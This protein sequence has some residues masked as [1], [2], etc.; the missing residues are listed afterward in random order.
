M[1]EDEVAGRR[2]PLDGREFEHASGLGDG[3]GAW[4]AAAPGV[5]GTERQHSGSRSRGGA[6]L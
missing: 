5:G 6:L 1:T 4:R 3:Q 2:R